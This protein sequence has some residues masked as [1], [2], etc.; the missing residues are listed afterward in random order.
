EAG[1]IAESIIDAAEH[2]DGRLPEAFAG[3][4]REVDRRPVE[5]PTASSPAAWS[6][7]APFLLLRALLG[8]E[9]RGDELVTAPVVPARFGR[10]ELLSVPGRWGRTDA[11]GGVRSTGGLK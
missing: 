9:P 10:I 6:T 5:L 8:L 7:G 4:D 11:L 1:R 3:F 2:F